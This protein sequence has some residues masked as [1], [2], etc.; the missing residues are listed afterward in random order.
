MG[1]RKFGSKNIGPQHVF[2]VSKLNQMGVLPKKGMYDTIL[3]DILSV[4]G[5]DAIENLGKSLLEDQTKFIDSPI[6]AS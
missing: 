4:I 1:I 3:K 2:A 6:Q 5:N